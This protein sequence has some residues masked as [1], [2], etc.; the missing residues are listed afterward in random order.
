M[1]VS[2]CMITYN[3]SKFISKAIEG[4]LKQET[5]FSYELVIGEDCSTDNT[6]EICNKYLQKHPDKIKLLAAETNQ[7]IVK[8]FI[9]TI[10]NCSGEYIAICEGDDYWIDTLKLQKQ[11]DYLDKNPDC[12]FCYTNCYRF[13][14]GVDEIREVLINDSPPT[15]YNLLYYLKESPLIPHCTKVFRRSAQPQELPD[16]FYSGMKSDFILNIF[17]SEKGNIGY[18][19]DITSCYR[20]HIGGIISQTKR[21]DNY[22]NSLLVINKLQDFFKPKYYEILQG[23]RAFHYEQIAFEYVRNKNIS[24]FIKNI[25]KALRI[26]KR[27]TLKYYYLIIKKGALIFF[28]KI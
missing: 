17:H 18:I 10:S 2:V 23:Y 15:K 19:N 22:Q 20:V 27:I 13:N 6:K 4:V 21:I 1:K 9:K 16:W 5:D 14:D 12:S 8:N 11:S 25:Y 28:N 24:L 3:H 7:G 26:R